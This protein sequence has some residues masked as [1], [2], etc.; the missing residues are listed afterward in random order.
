MNNKKGDLK[1][2]MKDTLKSKNAKDKINE[3]N[4]RIFLIQMA[5]SLDNEAWNIIRALNEIKK[6]LEEEV[7]NEC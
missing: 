6:E 7:K 4:E 3:I 1:A 5:D 2:L